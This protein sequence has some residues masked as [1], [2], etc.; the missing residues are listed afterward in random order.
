ML[1]DS[2]TESNFRERLPR[3]YLDLLIG[4]FDANEK[5]K[6]K[7]KEHAED[8]ISNT[9]VDLS[10]KTLRDLIEEGRKDCEQILFP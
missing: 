2:K 7:R 1:D 6:L 3:K 4:R 9:R 5:L 8:T 10:R